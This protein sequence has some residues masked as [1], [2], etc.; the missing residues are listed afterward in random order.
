MNKYSSTS[1][2]LFARHCPKALD[3]YEQHTPYDQARFAVG[4]AAHGVVEAL[5][6]YQA[7]AQNPCKSLAE[8]AQESA[9]KLASQPREFRGTISPPLA[10]EDVLAGRDLAV[11]YVEFNG[12]PENGLY[13]ME[14]GM[15][16]QGKACEPES[17]NCR[18]FGR[19]DVVHEAQIE[20]ADDWQLDAIIT[21]DFKTAWTA[22]DKL[23]HS[24]QIKGQAVLAWLNKPDDEIQAVVRRIANLRTWKHPSDTI[25]LDGD[26]EAVL[27]R[28][29]RDLLLACDAADKTR[30]ARPGVGGFDCLYLGQCEAAQQVFHDDTAT[31]AQKYVLVSAYREYYRE[32]LKGMLVEEPAKVLGGWVGY[33]TV[34][35]NTPSLEAMDLVLEGIPKLTGNNLAK[36]KFL[37][38]ALEL[39]AGNIAAFARR[40]FGGND[41]AA[42][43]WF[44]EHALSKK[45]STR[46]DIWRDKE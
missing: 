13:E 20:T 4:L 28:R 8:I 12:L 5:G 17:P 35:E 10:I 22:D 41:V 1:L 26:G 46:F 29:K 15:D 6:K 19:L 33:R 42:K 16:A 18:Y 2:N 7:V 44:L 38:D 34:S 27:N 11:N 43:Q 31:L 40:F 30:E 45:T 9:F 23:L 39:G 25:L 36:V 37:L 3:F 14:F 21:T 24:L 32:Q